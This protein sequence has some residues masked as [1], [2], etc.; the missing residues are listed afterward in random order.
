MPMINTND[1][2][3]NGEANYCAGLVSRQGDEKVSHRN[4]AAYLRYQA[5]AAR[6]DGFNHLCD[7]LNNAARLYDRREY[8][9]AY[10]CLL[11]AVAQPVMPR[12][13]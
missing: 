2:W 9:Q 11:K 1:T 13:R 8:A 3:K 12:R 6:K 7:A 5:K 4:V 10:A